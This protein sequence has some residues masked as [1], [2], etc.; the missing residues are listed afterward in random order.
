MCVLLPWVISASCF[1]ALLT[2]FFLFPS[3][4]GHAIPC[5]HT[6]MSSLHF[7]PLAL[8][9][10]LSKFMFII[11]T[12]FFSH[13]FSTVYVAFKLYQPPIPFKTP[14]SL[15]LDAQGRVVCHSLHYSGVAQYLFLYL[16][17]HT[18]ASLFSGVFV[19]RTLEEKQ[20]YFSSYCYMGNLLFGEQPSAVAWH[21]RILQALAWTFENVK[22]VVFILITFHSHYCSWIFSYLGRRRV[23]GAVE[24]GAR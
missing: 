8:T 12:L 19:I 22:R 9:S 5:L 4:L 7:F 16:L 2:F 23:M 11:G 10:Q 13:S 21:F 18:E 1:S 6:I 14:G 17:R 24:N 3:H 20:Q 15:F